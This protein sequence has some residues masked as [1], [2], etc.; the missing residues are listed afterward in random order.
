[1]RKILLTV[2]MACSALAHADDASDERG[3]V[4][5]TYDDF[6]ANYNS[7]LFSLNAHIAAMEEDG[8]DVYA[9]HQMCVDGN[10]LAQLFQ[11]NPRFAANFDQ[12]YAPDVTFAESLKSWRETAEASKSECAKIKQMYDKLDLSL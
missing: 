11:N 6:Q 5:A 3:A 1:M 8:T 7:L 9:T 2:L 10:Q 4:Q 12:V